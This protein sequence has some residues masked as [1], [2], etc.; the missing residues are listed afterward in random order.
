MPPIVRITKPTVLSVVRQY[1]GLL[2]QQIAHQLVIFVEA[3]D[4]F[5]VAA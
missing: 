5:T 1:S 4:G 3:E 2:L